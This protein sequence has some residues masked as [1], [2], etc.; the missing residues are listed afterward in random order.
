MVFVWVLFC[1]WRTALL[2]WNAAHRTPSGDAELLGVPACNG[3]VRNGGGA[4][5]HLKG[6]SVF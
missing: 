4:Q 3:G 2:S 5:D 6:N 1:V